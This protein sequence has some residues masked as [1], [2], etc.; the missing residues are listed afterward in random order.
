MKI[1]FAVWA[2]VL[3]V[4]VL[5]RDPSRPLPARNYIFFVSGMLCSVSWK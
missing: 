4:L 3:T 5:F 2:K 1:F